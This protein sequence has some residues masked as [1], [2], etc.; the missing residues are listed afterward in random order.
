MIGV[1]GN[2]PGLDRELLVP[3]AKHRSVLWTTRVWPG[4]VLVEGEIVGTWRR[5]SEHMTI[6]VWKRL[7][8]EARE[9]VEAEAAALPLPDLRGPIVL[10]LGG[11]ALTR[12]RNRITWIDFQ[13]HRKMNIMPIEAVISSDQ[14]QETTGNSEEI[15]SVL[16]VEP[17]TR[18]LKPSA[19][20]AESFCLISIN[21]K[22]KRLPPKNT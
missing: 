16:N 19:I 6:E 3:G 18:S 20:N 13:I 15:C 7:S 2:L 11:A 12:R 17:L 22:K 10:R 8:R 5:S 1:D 14:L 21:S 9:A 4:A